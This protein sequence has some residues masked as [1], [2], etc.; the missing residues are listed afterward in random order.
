[1]NPRL[2]IVLLA[3]VLALFAAFVG[4]G[5]SPEANENGAGPVPACDTIVGPGNRFVTAAKQ[6]VF[7]RVAIDML[8]GPSELTVLAD[9]TADPATVAADLLAQ[10]EHDPDAVP[11]LV[12]VDAPLIEAVNAELK[13]QLK[14]LPT[15]DTAGASLAKNCSW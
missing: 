12:S 13:N 10:A 7:G 6:L 3:F 9:A 2:R 4:S 14:K 8:A 11:V 1:M 15:K 5:C